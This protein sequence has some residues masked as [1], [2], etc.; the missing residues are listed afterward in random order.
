MK[1]SCKKFCE[2]TFLIERE[3]VENKYS[4]KLK[5]KFRYKHINTLS[6]KD[7]PLGNML[8]KMY[9]KSCNDIYCQKKCKPNGKWLKSYTKKRKE[10]LLNQGAI[11]GCRDL[12]K[13]F[14]NYYK[15]L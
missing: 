4:E 5:P 1:N 3:K 2:S 14:P 8:K 9:M 13:E 6:K 7:K 15:N 11:S 12:I 10:K